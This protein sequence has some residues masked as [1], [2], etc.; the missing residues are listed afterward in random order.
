[1]RE[2]VPIEAFI[3]VEAVEADPGP[4]PAPIP[5]PTFLS[6]DADG[7]WEARTSLFGDGER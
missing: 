5:A 7:A 4:I 2:F 1:M 6:A 3:R